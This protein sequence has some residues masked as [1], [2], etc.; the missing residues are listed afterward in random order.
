MQ[1]IFTAELRSTRVESVRVR[2]LSD[3]FPDPAC[4]TRAWASAGGPSLP[5]DR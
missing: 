1:A 5:E 3:R 2:F 4:A